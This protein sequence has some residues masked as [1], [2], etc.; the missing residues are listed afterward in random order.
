MGLTNSKVVNME[1][2]AKDYTVKMAK[3]EQDAAQ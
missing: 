3:L 2:F 1:E